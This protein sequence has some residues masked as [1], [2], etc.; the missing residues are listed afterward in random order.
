MQLPIEKPAKSQYFNGVWTYD[1]AIP[2]RWSNQLSYE[3]TDVGSWS[4]VGRREPMRN[5]CEVIIRNI[6]YI[7]GMGNQVSYEP[8]RYK[9]NLCNFVCRS[10]KKSG[11]QQ[12][13]NP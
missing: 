4:F 1:P 10:L 9:S 8:R 6:S 2:V 11:L 7:E 3:A 13:L 12:S 5:E